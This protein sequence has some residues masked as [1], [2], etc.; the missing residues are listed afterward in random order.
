MLCQPSDYSHPPYQTPTR[1]CGSPALF[2]HVHPARK[3]SELLAGGPGQPRAM[4]AG[5]LPAQ[6]RGSGI[7][8]HG[9]RKAELP[10]WGEGSRWGITSAPTRLR[11]LSRWVTSTWGETCSGAHF[12]PGRQSSG[13]TMPPPSA[14]CPLPR[15]ADSC[16]FSLRLTADP[17]KWGSHLLITSEEWNLRERR[18]SAPC[19]LASVGMSFQ[20]KSVLMPA[21]SLARCPI[22]PPLPPNSSTAPK[23][24]LLSFLLSPSLRAQNEGGAFPWCLPQAR[25]HFRTGV[26]T[27][28]SAGLASRF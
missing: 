12:C 21:G 6:S 13:E 23:M 25:G 10:R 19:H 7:G 15:E 22:L 16:R 14:A 24:T 8:A 9:H 5:S 1:V 3:G 17:H 18:R 26:S 4:G 28:A 20:T 27:S 11:T 2:G